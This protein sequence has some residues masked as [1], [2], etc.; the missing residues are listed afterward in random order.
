[1][2]IPARPRVPPLGDVQE[3]GELGRE[4]EK[5]GLRLPRGKQAAKGPPLPVSAPAW[6]LGE[7]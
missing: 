7:L 1:M 4:G 3:S 6:V 5:R 2:K